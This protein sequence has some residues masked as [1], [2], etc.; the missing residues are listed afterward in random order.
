MLL[1]QDATRLLHHIIITW[2]HGCYRMTGMI[3]PT[4]ARIVLSFDALFGVQ[5]SILARL[6]YFANRRLR[7]VG[8]HARRE[9]AVPG[10]C[11]LH[12]PLEPGRKENCGCRGDTSRRP[13]YR[14]AVR[15]A[16]VLV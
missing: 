12:R 14:P 2:V 13:M 3:T 5:R 4:Y 16:I 15:D 1:G 8:R 6:H 10:C 7:P 11:G 9:D